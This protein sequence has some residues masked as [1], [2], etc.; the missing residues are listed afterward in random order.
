[1]KKL[2]I[3]HGNCAD[4]FGAAWA[5]RHALGD[6]VEFHAGHY[7]HEAPEV[8]GRDVIMV[9]FSY[10]RDVLVKM[11][12]AANSVTI[13][14]HHKSAESDLVDLPG[15]VT[16]IFD[17][18]RSGAMMAWEYFNKGEAPWLIK[19]I[20][21]RDL[22]RFK[23]A[24]T[25]EI[26][27]A[28][29][30]YPYDVEV[31]DQLILERTTESLFEE[32]VAI[33]RKHMKDVNEL[34]RVAAHR[35]VIAGYNVPV[36]NAPYFFSSEAGNIMSENEP[37]AACYYETEKGRVYSLRSQEYGVDVSVI[38]TLFGGGGHKNAAGFRVGF[39]EIP[40]LAEVA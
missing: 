24:G 28:V 6:D 13:L 2:C 11:A 34:I 35:T 27:A 39:D 16:A 8:T 21:D 29:F 15:N 22:W 31:W 19:H 9:D 12:M 5:V 14:D 30:S 17:M 7:G 37:F 23:L 4:G 18:N 26:Q 36:M 33:L 3:Y 25:K 10:K 32:G 38:A 20:E 40:S 1:M